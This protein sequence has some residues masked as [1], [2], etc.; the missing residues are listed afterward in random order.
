MLTKKSLFDIIK[1]KIY[2]LGF[3]AH[4]VRANQP[5]VLLRFFKSGR[6]RGV[7]AKNGV[8]LLAFFA[9]MPSKKAAKNLNILRIITLFL[10]ENSH[11]EK[12]LQKEMAFC[13]HDGNPQS[14]FHSLRGTPT[15]RGLH[16]S[17]R[18]TFKKVDETIAQRE[19]KHIIKPFIS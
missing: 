15:P 14:S 3:I 16:Y 17:W 10:W 19:R 18:A 6:L 4:L 7:S 1:F 2:K 5:V 12:A 13:A 9:P 11:K 8:S